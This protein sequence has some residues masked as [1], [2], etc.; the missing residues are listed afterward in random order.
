MFEIMPF[1]IYMAGWKT[2][3]V[4]V[5]FPQKEDI[6]LSDVVERELKEKSPTTYIV[7]ARDLKSAKSRS[8]H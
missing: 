8:G 6:S 3:F 2:S 7:I 4:D 5:S 1:C